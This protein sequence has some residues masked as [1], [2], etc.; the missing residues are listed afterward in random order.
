MK[1]FDWLQNRTVIQ[2][3]EWKVSKLSN[4]SND[5]LQLAL[6]SGFQQNRMIWVCLQLETK[7]KNVPTSK[8]LTGKQ[9]GEAARDREAFRACR[10][11]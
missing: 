11:P 8:T 3:Q 2:Q 10:G 7:L 9:P 6:Q 5:W 1:S 4:P